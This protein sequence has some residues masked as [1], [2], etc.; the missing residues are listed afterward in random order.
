MNIF[1]LRKQQENDVY[2]QKKVLTSTNPLSLMIY[3]YDDD[4]IVV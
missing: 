1:E 2:V 3:Y 4:S